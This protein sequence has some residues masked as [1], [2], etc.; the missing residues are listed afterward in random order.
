MDVIKT[1][2]FATPD[3][4]AAA[5]ELARQARNTPVMKLSSDSPTF[6]EVA[7][8]ALN[9]QVHAM[10]LAHGLPEIFGHYGMAH[11]GE[12]TRESRS[13]GKEPDTW[14]GEPN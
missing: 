1:G 6:S 10:A 4:K 11:D 14:D 12:F 9:F 13:D 8:R 2:V 3:E 5:I 7:W